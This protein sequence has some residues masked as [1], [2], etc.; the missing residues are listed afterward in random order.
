MQKY[1]IKAAN[2]ASLNATNIKNM[3]VPLPPKDIQ[4][5][6]VKEVEGLVAKEDR[7]KEEVVNFTGLI[8]NEINSLFAKNK[9]NSRIKELFRINYETLDPTTKWENEE[10]TYVD[11]D[12]ISKGNGNIVFNQK[13]LGKDAP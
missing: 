6:I 2:Q 1:A 8:S 9:K 11:I 10:F 12:S 7:L 5:K 4:E 13:L 3:K